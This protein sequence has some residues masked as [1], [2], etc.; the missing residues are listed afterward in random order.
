MNKKVLVAMSGGVDSAVA[1]LLL[2]RQGYDVVGVTCQIWL[3][4][5]CH[6]KSSKSC[7]GNEAIDDARETAHMLG[8]RH[9]VFN[10]RELFQEK[11][12]DDFCDEYLEGS[13]PNPCMNC[14]LHI[15]SIDLL[16]KA[17]GMGFDYLATGHYVMN[18]QDPET[19]EYVL[20]KGVDST[21]DQ[22]YF[23]YQLDQRKLSHLLFPLGRLTKKEVREIARENG[24]PVAEKEESQD[25][26]FIPDGDY[27]KFIEEY[28]GVRGKPAEIRLRNGK[29]LGT[30]KPYYC[31]T[32]GQRKGLGIAWKEPLYVLEV[33]GDAGVVTVGT[34]E[35]ATCKGLRASEPFL[36]SG[37]GIE[38]GREVL[39]KVRY[40]SRPVRARYF[41]EE[42]GF[43]LEFLEEPGAVAKGQSAVL[44]SLKDPELVL[45]GGRITEVW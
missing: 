38:E 37:K 18:E 31:Y 5:I 3:E 16:E 10:Y 17:I 40:R 4:D 32:I 22:S 2:Q 27:G 28:R 35:E 26:C 30:G 12:I 20:R 45:G 8:I 34:R 39:V 24:I 19:G 36:I 41:R 44:Y 21:K 25:I 6:V 14:N 33:D 9:V 23:L 29:R 11:V 15:R 42:Q 43:R 7:C 1:A 13:T